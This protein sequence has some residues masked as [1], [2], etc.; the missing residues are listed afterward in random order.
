[1]P[2]KERRKKEREDKDFA[3]IT[4]LL[5]SREVKEVMKKTD[6]AFK[7]GCKILRELC[8]AEKKL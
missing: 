5:V 6:P 4:A 7:R 3:Y 2:D 8:Q 1:M